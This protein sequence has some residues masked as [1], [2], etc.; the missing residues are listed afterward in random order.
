V[1]S[2]SLEPAVHAPRHGTIG[3]RARPGVGAA[4]GELR[5]KASDCG[6]L[7]GASPPMQRVYELIDRVAPTDAGVLISG[8]TGTGKELVA[9]AIHGLSRRSSQAF[10]PLNCGAVSATLIE[11][12][13]FGHERGSF[14]GAERVHRGYFERAHRG[15][16]FLDEISTMPSDLQVRLLRVLE[17]AVVGRVGGT[18]T[19]KVDVRIV[20]AT[21]QPPEEAVAAGRL[22]LDLLYRL[23]VF[24]MTLPPLRERG[25]DVLLLAEHF[26]ADLNAAEGT[27]REL[28]GA[29]LERLRRHPWPGNVRELRNVVH[30]AFILAG[31]TDA[32]DCLPLPRLR[33]VSGVPALASEDVGASSLVIR[34]GTTLAEAERRLILA[35]IDHF[36][37]HKDEAAQALGMGVNT[38]YNRLREYKASDRLPPTGPRAS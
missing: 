27:A 17:T 29:C 6:L 31:T 4:A 30:R 16:L 13:L 20:A 19:I 8:E 32:V 18:E 12:E 38:L 1:G 21:N 2:A 9:Q 5:R 34:L 14:T 35:T 23:N 7:I 37:G 24:P 36:S 25:D 22:R 33:S 15:T 3:V 26:L 10:L 28:T 11:S